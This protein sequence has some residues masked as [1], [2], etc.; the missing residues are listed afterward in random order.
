MK[1]SKNKRGIDVYWYFLLLA[2]IISLIS[3]STT[4][5]QD[6]KEIDNYIGEYQFAI[7]KSADY[8]SNSLLY[9]EHVAKYALKRSI[10]DLAD[11]GGVPND[12]EN[13]CGMF[14]GASIWYGVRR[15]DSAYEEINCFDENNIN[16]SLIQVFDENLNSGLSNNPLGLETDNYE[17]S[18]KDNVD[19]YGLAKRPL[20]VD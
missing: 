6:K 20:N 13:E 5:S 1:L 12:F 19:L 9:A 17:Y 10:Y 7:T 2:V 18:I 16:D 8:A 4:R 14:L 11:K 15:I 3:Y